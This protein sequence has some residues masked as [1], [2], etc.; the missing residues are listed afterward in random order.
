MRHSAISMAPNFRKQQ[1]T[2]MKCGAFTSYHIQPG[3]RLGLFSATTWLLVST[4][5]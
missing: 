5:N 1:K 3:N 2:T 4:I